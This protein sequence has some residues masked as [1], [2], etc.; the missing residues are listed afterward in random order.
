MYPGKIERR[1]DFERRDDINLNDSIFTDSW[2]EELRE[3]DKH[4]IVA[5]IS[6]QLGPCPTNLNVAE[7]IFEDLKFEIAKY[8]IHHIYSR[9]EGI[10]SRLLIWLDNRT[11]PDN[12]AKLSDFIDKYMK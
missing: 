8:V 3:I 4:E 9:E 7:R 11:N 10:R 12:A 1:K 2:R 5:K 6:D